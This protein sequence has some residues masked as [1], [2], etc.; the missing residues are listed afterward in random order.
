[1]TYPDSVLASAPAIGDD[2]PLFEIVNGQRVEL[3]PMSAYAARVA[4]RLHGHLVLYANANP[5]GEPAMEVIFRLP[6][7]GDP[8]RRPDV[9]FVSFE[10]WPPNRPMPGRGNAWDVVPDLAVEVVSPTDRAEEVME[11]VVEYFQAG[12]RL[13]WIVYPRQRFV[14]V[15]E[16]LTAVRGLTRTDELDG[17]TVCPASDCPWPRSSPKRRPA[18]EGGA[19]PCRPPR[20]LTQ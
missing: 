16:S 5:I 8:S 6:L 20:P 15:H 7:N 3:P 4:S 17:G 18:P 1:M 10:R 12:V 19:S 2:E 13:V 11:K 9:A 14:Y